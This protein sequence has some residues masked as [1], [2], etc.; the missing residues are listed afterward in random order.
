MASESQLTVANV[1]VVVPLQPLSF[2]APPDPTLF[3]LS[4]QK[5]KQP[6]LT[7]K[8]HE[9]WGAMKTMRRSRQARTGSPGSYK[10]FVVALISSQSLIKRVHTLSSPREDQLVVQVEDE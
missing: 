4:R 7:G 5:Q 3:F 2:L 1:V 9:T 6:S 8:I 10:V